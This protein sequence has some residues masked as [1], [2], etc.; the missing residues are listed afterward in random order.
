MSNGQRKLGLHQIT[1][2]DA[3]PVELIQL[4]AETGY[5]EV[6]LF[7]H[8]PTLS[9]DD[10][11]KDDGVF[12]RVDRDN[13]QAVQRQLADTGIRVANVEFFS[14]TPHMILSDYEYGLELGAQLQ[15]RTAVTHIFD[16]DEQR[17]VT[18]LGRLVEMAAE[19]HLNVAI[20][21]MGLSPVCSSLAQAMRF[22][23]SVNHPNLGIAID[24]LHMVRT[25]TPPSA[26]RHI[27]PS[28]F[29][30]AQIC[31]GATSEI[32]GDYMEE[33][34]HHRLL[35]GSGVFPLKAIFNALPRDLPIDVEVPSQSR[36]D[37][38][39]SKE[40]HALSALRAAQSILETRT[41][42]RDG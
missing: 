39:I 37:A 36:I 26:L 2:M 19:Y 9:A 11:T 4:A 35:P 22:I 13:L 14:I 21:V 20:E 5:Q 10:A 28:L 6:C 33:A 40:N 41:I 24:A 30:Y 15:A 1:A 7:T 27:P 32:T 8:L 18:Q 23:N 42:T 25:G 3:T 16:E 29:T 12:P 17:A 31:D 38:G 34:L